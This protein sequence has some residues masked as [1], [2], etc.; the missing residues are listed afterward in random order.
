MTMLESSTNNANDDNRDLPSDSLNVLQLSDPHLFADP[1]GRLLGM[2]TLASLQRVIKDAS[3][4]LPSTD[5]TL[6]TGDLVHDASAAGYSLLKK[7]LLHLNTPTY[8]LPGNHDDPKILNASI[9]GNPIDTP[10]SIQKKNWSIILLDS[11]LPGSTKGHLDEKQL[12]RLQKTLSNHPNHHTLIC[13]HHHTVPVKSKWL[14]TMILSNAEDF[15]SIT[16]QHPQIKGVTCGHI[17]Q[18]FEATRKNLLLLGSPSTCFQFTPE[19]I[20]FDI[21]N[22]PPGYRQLT[23]LPNGTIITKVIRLKHFS[24][25]IDMS[26]SGY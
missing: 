13:L 23:L 2:H 26:S 1:D 16:D 18:A 22:K 11:N 24:N 8:C 19:S 21:D 25:S 12:S 6:V 9:S 4:R 3:K 10:F 7:E 17:H 14:D 5:F 20:D 15:F